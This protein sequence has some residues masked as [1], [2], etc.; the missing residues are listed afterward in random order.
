MFVVAVGPFSTALRIDAS[1]R[2]AGTPLGGVAPDLT[3][4]LSPIGIPSFLANPSRWTEFVAESGD[5]AL[6]ATL[7]DL[8]QTLP[9]FAEHTF[10]DAFGPIIGQRVRR[11]GTKAARL[12]RIRGGAVGREPRE[13]R[14]RR[15]RH[16]SPA[17]GIC[18]ISRKAPQRW[19]RAWMR[20]R[21]ASTHWRR[22]STARTAADAP[23][24]P[25]VVP[26]PRPDPGRR[27]R[28][29]PEHGKEVAGRAGDHEQVPHEVGVAQA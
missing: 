12:P 19:P 20:S 2:V 18:A 16:S 4:T 6:A 17:R 27:L 9:W 7:K 29:V 21:R 22:A 25:N 23:A 28:R 1:G 10:A 11:R 15:G 14:P 13:L 5:P 8:A 26:L 3:L 24:H